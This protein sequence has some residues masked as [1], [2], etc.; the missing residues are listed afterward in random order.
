MEEEDFVCGRM[1]ERKRGE[2]EDSWC[3]GL[4]KLLCW[5]WGKYV[6]K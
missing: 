1:E 2:S 3:A 5:V 4:N 6:Y